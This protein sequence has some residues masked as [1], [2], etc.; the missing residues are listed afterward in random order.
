VIAAGLALIFD[1]D[2]VLID[3]NPLHRE[4]WAAFNRR[5]GLETTEDMHQRMYG[6]RNDA[7]LRDFFGDAL[8]LE[9]LSARSAAKEALY[10]EMMAARLDEFLVPGVKEFLEVYAATPK[11]LASNA[12]PENIDFLLDRAGL[13]SYFQVVVDGRQVAQ[14]KPDPEI[15]LKTSDLL[16]TPPGDCIVF[17]DSHAGVAAARAA[18][19]RVVGVSTTEDDLPGSTITIDNFLS[20][21]LSTWLRA[22]KRAQ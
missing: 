4:S 2:G 18:G 20:G 21:E 12:E 1:M 17:E 5:Y 9:E 10:R 15:Y 6:R 22:Q 13:R 19:M 14:P 11:G 16:N 8:T 7:I 3:S